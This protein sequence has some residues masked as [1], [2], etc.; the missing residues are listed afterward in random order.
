MFYVLCDF[1]ALTAWNG[2]LKCQ[3]EDLM[4]NLKNN[5]IMFGIQKKEQISLLRVSGTNLLDFYNNQEG[6][7]ATIVL[8]QWQEKTDLNLSYS[9]LPLCSG[10]FLTRIDA[11][12]PNNK[13]RTRASER[14]SNFWWA[15]FTDKHKR[16]TRWAL[17]VW[18]ETFNFHWQAILQLTGTK[19]LGVGMQKASLAQLSL[20][21]RSKSLLA[22]CTLELQQ[23]PKVACWACEAHF[24]RSL[25]CRC[26]L[27]HH[28]H[29]QIHLSECWSGATVSSSLC[30]NIWTFTHSWDAQ[31]PM[32]GVKSCQVKLTQDKNSR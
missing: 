4:N 12:Q 27:I 19:F 25:Y 30:Q 8:Q 22:A 20:H 10:N 31:W 28:P 15:L 9:W 24:A 21:K 11:L 29:N 18:Q 7:S 5:K 32:R 14:L 2:I 13:Q 3:G 6:Q 17:A 23:L 16:K 1:T 26:K